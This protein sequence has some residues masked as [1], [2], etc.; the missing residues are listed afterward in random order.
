LETI[1][2]DEEFLAGPY[3]EMESN[4]F[5]ASMRLVSD[6]VEQILPCVWFGESEDGM[7]A[8]RV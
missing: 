3:P 8:W 2:E 5:A 6:W 7:C 1:Y 4:V